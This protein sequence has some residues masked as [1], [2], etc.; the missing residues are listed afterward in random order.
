MTEQTTELTSSSSELCDTLIGLLEDGKGVD[1]IHLDVSKLTTITDFMV[2]VTGTSS[3]HVNALAANTVS[4][5]RDKGIRPR[6]LE[7]QESGEWVLLD[8][9]DVIIH[10]MQKTVRELYDLEGLW[11]SGFSEALLK[12]APDSAD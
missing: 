11:Q 3:R 1:I 6:G 7:G 12:R 9:G 8:F 4:S 10:I 2:I 5:M